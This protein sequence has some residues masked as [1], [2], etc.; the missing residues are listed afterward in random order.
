MSVT[1]VPLQPVKRGYLTWLWIGIVAALVVAGA[2]AYLG[3]RDPVDSFLS[4][5]ARQE[6]VKTTASGLQY[7]VLEPGSG[8]TPT[9]NDVVLINYEGRFT[10]G[11]VF[12]KSTQP[13][14]MS[15]RGVVPG[16][17]EALKMMPKG[18][19]YRFW[20][21]PE[22]GYGAADADLGGDPTREKLARSVLVFEVEMVDFLPESVVRQMQQAGPPPAE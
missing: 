1:A 18:S 14:P 8:P 3:T 10:D 20:L 19:K 21:P 2:L 13:T 6:G 16:F 12:D 11:E 17:S 9:E 7:Q 4:G 22:L 15:P 5:N